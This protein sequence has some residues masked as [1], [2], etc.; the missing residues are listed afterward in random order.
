MTTVSKF[1]QRRLSL[2]V[3]LLAVTL[4][5]PVV[6]GGPPATAA[7]NA[8]VIN[9]LQT[10]GPG[11]A[12]DEFIELYNGTTG[13]VAI[14]GWRVRRSSSTG[15][16][17]TTLA[18][19]PTGRQL[20][21]NG[22]YLLAASGYPGASDQTYSSTVAANGGIALVRP[23][24]T[25]V[26]AVGL[27]TS[28]AFVERRPAAV[29]PPGQSLQRLP[30]GADT[31]DNLADF[32]AAPPTPVRSGATRPNDVRTSDNAFTPTPITVT[33]GDRV[34]WRNRGSVA[35][36][37]T[38]DDRAFN[39]GSLPPGASFAAG[40]PNIGT[41]RYYCALHGGPNGAGM[42]GVV[43]VLPR[44]GRFHALAPTRILD[45]R[46]SGGKLAAGE[47]RAIPI[48]GSG[49]VPLAGLSAVVLNATVTEPAASGHLTVFPAGDA[50]PLASN[51]NFTA[52]GTVANLV[53]VR[54][55]RN[56][57]IAVNNPIAAAHLVL[58][59]AGYYDRS[60]AG[61]DGRYQPATPVRLLDT[62]PSGKPFGAG[63]TRALSVGTGITAV[64][65][66]ITVTGP[67]AASFITAWPA[68]GDVPNASNVNFVAGQTVGNRAI[69]AVPTTGKNAGVINLRNAAGSV[70]VIV[71][72]SGTFS[73]TGSGAGAVTSIT[74]VRILDTRITANRL[75]PD[76]PR[77]LQVSGAAGVPVGARAVIL[78]VT[79][80]SP[81]ANSYLTV[82]PA[83]T[84]KPNTSDC[85]YTPGS[86]VPNLVMVKLG[87][88]GAVNLNNAVGTTDVVADVF[89]YVT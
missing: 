62:R 65:L 85:N 55:G 73:E 60:P 53:S 46:K 15:V 25:V 30:D 88:G 74:P 77:L 41:F 63:E 27:S 3:L 48:A 43:T 12:T 17:I 49:G 11:G 32:A 14:G 59:V 7:G 37:V 56:G 78:N 89:G 20:A 76:V 23:D 29:A 79:V 38:A 35:H 71:D 72:L 54:V 40:F 21:P 18:T 47:T 58:D 22:S 45:T 66:N 83:G 67:T 26:D 31:D 28:S 4:V 64:A 70:H 10:Q 2:L 39:S 61:P 81:S 75:G 80:V 19:I 87:T 51:L 44:R 69:V 52:G 24:G 42:A 13:P 34:F 82:W 8:P 33:E 6:R 57:A 5:A 1:H 86:V 9:E 84:A 68:G 16:T 36:T 50:V